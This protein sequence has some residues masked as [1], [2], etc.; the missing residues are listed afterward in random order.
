[1]RAYMPWPLDVDGRRVDAVQT[2][3]VATHP[4]HRGGGVSS[5]L[6]DHAIAALRETKQF[7]LG[8]PNDSSLSISSK[9]GW[10]AAGRLPVWVRVRRP[11]R[12]ARRLGALRSAGRSLAVP[13]VEAPL[14]AGVLAA[15]DSVAELLHQPRTSGPH[16]ATLPGVD[17]L[18][19]RYEPLLGDYRAVAEYS[20][21]ALTGLAI[22][23]LR[24]RGEL[25]EGERL[26]A[27]G[28]PRRPPHGRAPAAPDRPRRAARLPGRGARGRHRTG[29][30]AA[31]RGLRPLAGRRP[32]AGR[33]P[34]LRRGQARPAPARLVVALVRRPRAP[35]ALLKDLDQALRR[36]PV[37]VDRQPP[38]ALRLGEGQ[39]AQSTALSVSGSLTIVASASSAPPR[40]TS[41]LGV[42]R[43]GAPALLVLLEAT[44]VD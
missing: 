24:K 14:A 41:V 21:G 7:A 18:R 43:L 44:A 3:D 15:G 30:H 39:L 9:I 10:Q 1:M 13:S 8:L 28:A 12:V 36:R 32:G 35:R 25:W 20:G 26:R 4:G 11:L 17:Y 19:W 27:A 31:P 34:L 29:R 38:G 33:D 42:T 37:A 16:L 23:G 6:A 22:F 5:E 40:A 2:V